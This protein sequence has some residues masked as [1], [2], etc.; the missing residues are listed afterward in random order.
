MLDTTEL[1]YLE[2]DIKERLTEALTL[3]NRT[4][5]LG[6]LLLLL[7][8]DEYLEDEPQFERYIET[9][10]IVVVGESEANV[11]QL[12]GVAK[13]LG[14]K[15]SRLEFCLDYNDAKKFDFNKTQWNPKYILILAGPMPHSTISKGSSSSAIAKVENEEGYPPV[16]R[17]GKNGLKISKTE[18]KEKL[19]Q[20]IQNGY[21]A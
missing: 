11:D 8:M 21:V 13:S 2:E 6:E 17:L 4:D 15:K 7:G 3:L 16:M 12:T 20:A 18:F 10:K 1:F 19:F 9:G 5:R 14:I